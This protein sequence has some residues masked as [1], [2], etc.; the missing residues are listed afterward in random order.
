MRDELAST[1]AA[2]TG[3]ITGANDG[4]ARL[5]L[6]RPAPDAPVELQADFTPYRRYYLAQQRHMAAGIGP[7]R[8][9]AREALAGSSAALWQLAE[10][11]ATLDQALGSREGDLLATVPALLE[12]HFGKLRQ[13]HQAALAE[14]GTADDPAQWLLPDGWLTRF[15]RDLQ[16]VL[17][18]ELDLRL[19]PVIGLIEAH[20]NDP[21]MR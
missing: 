19:Q 12:R 9:K 6:P 16:D 1:R 13:A 7:L 21:A 18:A 2:L 20:S 14:S 8:L 11:D 15:H 17:L 4:K 10:L 3:A 5:K